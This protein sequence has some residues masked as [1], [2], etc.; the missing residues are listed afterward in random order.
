MFSRRN[1]ERRQR[2]RVAIFD[3]KRTFDPAVRETAFHT[4]EHK[5]HMIIH[6]DQAEKDF[7]RAGAPKRRANRLSTCASYQVIVRRPVFVHVLNSGTRLLYLSTLTGNGGMGGPARLL[8]PAVAAVAGSTVVLSHGPIPAEA[9]AC[10][11]RRAGERTTRVSLTHD[12]LRSL[13]PS[14]TSLVT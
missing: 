11:T 4:T 9:V 1:G 14:S 7:T 2:N 6:N 12:S 8:R 13:G 5:T 10:K 3:P